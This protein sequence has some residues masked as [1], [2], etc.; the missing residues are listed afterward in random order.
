MG[1][2][3]GIAHKYGVAFLSLFFYSPP[4]KSL[5]PPVYQSDTVNPQA[6]ALEHL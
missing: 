5:D 6:Y 4:E 2:L 3:L 1:G